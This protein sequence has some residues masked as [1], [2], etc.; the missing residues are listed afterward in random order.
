MTEFFAQY[1]ALLWDGLFETLYMTILATFFAYLLG[2]PAGILLT[3]TKKGGIASAP[4]FHTI[5]SWIINVLRSLP[6]IILMFFIIPFTRLVA[7]TTIG[8]T[9]ALV[10]LTISAAPFIARIVEQSLA[11]VD[12]G[13]IEAAQCMGATRWQID[14]K[15]VV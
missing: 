5:F 7:G 12:H 15:S 3:I 13:V 1:G 14:R 6:F 4:V 2:L 8:A 11:E 9:A 10:P